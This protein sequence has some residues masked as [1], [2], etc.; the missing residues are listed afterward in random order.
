MAVRISRYRLDMSDLPIRIGTAAPPTD[1]V[2]G[3]TI[4]LTAAANVALGDACYINSSGKADL[5]NATAAGTSSAIVLAAATIAANA[6]GV[7]LLHGIGHL[8][9]LNPGWTIGGL[10][11]ASVTGTS[12]NTLTQSAPSG[13]GNVIQILGVAIAADTIYLNPQLVQVEHA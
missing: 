5:V 11:Y 4:T 1:T 7:F 6:T 8:H 12:G 13:T 2:T 3:L 10:I 9:T